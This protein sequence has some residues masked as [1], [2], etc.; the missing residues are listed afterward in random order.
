MK[1]WEVNVWTKNKTDNDILSWWG[2]IYMY[3]EGYGALAFFTRLT[4]SR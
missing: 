2:Y 1:W 4:E 3:E